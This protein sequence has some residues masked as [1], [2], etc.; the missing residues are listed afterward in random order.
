MV[1]SVSGSCN[2]RDNS[3]F[4]SITLLVCGLAIIIDLIKSGFDII[5]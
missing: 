2:I 1:L 4:S 3:G 5:D